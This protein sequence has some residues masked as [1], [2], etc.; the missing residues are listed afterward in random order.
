[1][2]R[3]RLRG[4]GERRATSRSAATR[5]VVSDDPEHRALPL[6]WSPKGWGVYVNTVRRVRAR[7]GHRDRPTQRV[8]RYP[9]TIAVLD[10]FLFVGEPAEI[11][12]QYTALTG[13][14]G[15]PVLWAM[16]LAAPGGR[17]NGHPRR[18]RW[19]S[20]P[21]CAGSPAGCRAV[22]A[23]GGLWTFQADKPADGMG[24]RTLSGCA[25]IVRPV[26][27]ASRACLRAGLSRHPAQHALCSRNWKTVAGCSR[28]TTA[29]R[30]SSMATACRGGQPFGLLDL[31]NR[32]VYALWAER[33][34]QLVEDGL[35][36]PVLR[37]RS[38]PSPTAL[39]RGD[40]ESGRGA[41]HDLSFAGAPCPVRRGG[42]S[43]GAAGRGGAQHRSLP[44]PPNACRWQNGPAAS[45]T[46][47]R[48]CSTRC[49]RPC[50]SVPAR[51]PV[52][53]A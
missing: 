50:P 6:A 48:A 24:R 43:Q 3:P 23:A 14:A 10:L 41:A 29:T 9:W 12:N 22:G 1:M 28:A 2:R 49:A 32:D 30:R 15:Q 21:A 8:H 36:A 19:S 40:G 16:G 51:V 44:P 25:S 18:P 27:Q 38:W 53:V 46:T 31:T 11:L 5:N 4:L 13:R 52:Q 17:R 26:P 42:R 34:R 39:P 20:V 47:G 45:A 33:Q 7:A 35:D 37:H